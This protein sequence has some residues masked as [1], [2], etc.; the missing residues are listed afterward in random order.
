MNRTPFRP[1]PR[2]FLT[3]LGVPMPWPKKIRLLF[4]NLALRIVLRQNCCGHLGE[5]GC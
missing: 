3:N 4:R 5:P 1:S 2:D